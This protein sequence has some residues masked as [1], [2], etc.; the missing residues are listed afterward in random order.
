[1]HALLGRWLLLCVVEAY[2]L[3]MSRVSLGFS[4]WAKGCRVIEVPLKEQRTMLQYNKHEMLEAELQEGEQLLWSGQ[5]DPLRFAQQSIHIFIIGVAWTGFCISFILYGWSEVNSIQNIGFGVFMSLFLLIGYTMLATP[6][7]SYSEAL[8]I[9]Y[10]ITSERVL[11][12]TGG[13]ILKVE[14]Y[15]RNNLG[16][17]KRTERANRS[18]NLS[19]AQEHYK[20]S[21]GDKQTREIELVGI[22]DVREVET[23]LRNLQ[24]T[25]S[26]VT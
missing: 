3:R 19:F 11:I 20:D 10:G 1:M 2:T 26:R 12:V 21:D 8:K 14:S 13:K 15:S 22:P 7:S 16:T 24:A 4:C 9:A 6:F 18:G 17:I 23:L 25:G 5:P